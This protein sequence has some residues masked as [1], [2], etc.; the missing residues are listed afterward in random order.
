MEFSLNS[1]FI[2]KVLRVNQLLVLVVG[3]EVLDHDIE[4]GSWIGHCHTRLARNVRVEFEIFRKTGGQY[5]PDTIC[6]QL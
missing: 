2:H 4:H 3:E 6:V 1:L 5:A